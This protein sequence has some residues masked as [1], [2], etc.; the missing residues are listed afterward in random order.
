MALRY[1][2]ADHDHPR[3]F[4]GISILPT[5]NSERRRNKATSEGERKLLFAVLEDA[6]LC[7]LQDAGQAYLGNRP[8]FHG[9]AEWISSGDE[10]DPFAFA[11]L[12]GS[13]HRRRSSTL[14]PLESH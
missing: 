9:A 1:A 2:A 5:K 3:I 11:C 10:S 7:Y 6:I 8:E 12:R 4:Q 14:G 13:K